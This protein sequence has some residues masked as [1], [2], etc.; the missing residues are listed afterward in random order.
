MSRLI[1]CAGKSESFEFAVPIGIGLVDS[2]IRLSKILTKLTLFDELKCAKISSE[3]FQEILA[4]EYIKC[5][6]LAKFLDRQSKNGKKF[7]PSEVVF[8][9]TAGLYDSGELFEIF[10]YKNAAN[11][12]ISLLDDKSYVP[13]PQE[14]FSDV[15]RETF[16]N[17]S[18]FITKD[19]ESA[20]KLHNLGAKAENME[21]FSVL[22]TAEN[23]HIP[24]RG[25]LIATN[26]CEPNA[27]A[28]FIKN[29]ALA[30]DMLT[31]Y[32]EIEGI[33]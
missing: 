9:G 7:L 27:H 12:E 18:N 24:A 3:I 26:F 29:H 13:V 31:H 10:E 6:I 2:A 1:V 15:S 17:S 8:I 4:T 16:I 14:I 32:L 25:I 5:E 19:K 33:I 23:F 11:I 30:K 21:L 28:Q 20:K 22:K